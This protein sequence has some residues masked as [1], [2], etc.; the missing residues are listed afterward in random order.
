MERGQPLVS[1][2][3]CTYNGAAYLSAQLHTL[4]NQT[5][6]NLEIIVVD[7]CST[8]NTVAILEQYAARYSNIKIHRN[9]QNL[10]YVKN[11][12]KAI[13]LCE[14]DLIA[15]ADQDDIWEL[16]KIALMVN[17]MGENILL[18][19]DSAF[20]DE[21]GTSLEKKVS[22]VRRFYSGNDSRVFLFENCV[23]GHAMLFKRSLL[24]HF[25]GFNN[26]IIHDWWLTY[27]ALNNGQIGFLEQ[28]LVQ[29]RQHRK[30]STNILRMERDTAVKNSSPEK[31]EQ[32]LKVMTALVNYPYNKDVAFKQQ[33]LSL[34]Q[35]RMDS[36]FSFGLAAFIF[37]HRKALLYIQKKSALSKFNFVLKF[38]WGYKLKTLFLK[39]LRNQGFVILV[40]V[41]YRR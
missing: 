13:R 40:T 18:Y 8:D 30:A 31:V 9:I 16:D 1:I 35:K 2:A 26:V 12:E 28:A 7:D 6:S 21:Q 3:L 5:Y 39:A 25:E 4:V 20:I 41:F 29:Y 11:Y 23:S 36:Y 32:Q 10:G 19:H 24:D 38:A 33:L 14:G 37:R 34:M 17:G 15:P 27:L 22:D